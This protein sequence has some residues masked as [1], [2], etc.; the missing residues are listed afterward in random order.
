VEQKL[1]LQRRE[2]PSSSKEKDMV[3]SVIP[4]MLNCIGVLRDCL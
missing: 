1:P 2:K 3:Y 4:T